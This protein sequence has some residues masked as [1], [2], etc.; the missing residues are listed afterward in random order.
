MPA[1]IE[2]TAEQHRELRRQQRR[3]V[4]RVAERIHY[5][6]LFARGYLPEAIAR[7][8]EVDERT[9]EHWLERYRSEGVAGLSDRPRSGRPRKASAAAQA[10]ATRC[11]ASAPSEVGVVDAPRTTWTRKLLRTH[12]SERCDCSL[13]LG[14]VARLIRHLGFVWRRPKLGLKLWEGAEEARA[15]S[16]EIVAAARAVYPEAPCLFADECDVHQVPVVRGQ[17]QR[18]GEQREVPT[19]GSN[20]K[21][22]VF[23]FLEV[24]SGAWHSFFTERKRSEEFIGCL[25]GLARH[26]PEGTVLLFVDRASIHQSEATLRWLEEHPRFVMIYLP[27]YSGHKSNPVEKVWWAMKAE[28]AANH[29][30]PDLEAVR[31]AIER[32]FARFTRA[33]AL[34]L[35]ASYVPAPAALALAA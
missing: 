23:G 35:T 31:T 5:V 26:Y 29:L 10:E 13:S 11:L 25:E 3:A 18:P 30:Y 15:M 6:L 4:G 34:Q 14:S 28:V 9:V 27:P 12:L 16:R 1:P 21:Q 19:P 32:F 24:T 8:Y 17:Y 7:L 22:P 20:R 2:L 33:A